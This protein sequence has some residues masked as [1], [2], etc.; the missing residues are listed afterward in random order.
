M[1]RIHSLNDALLAGQL[2]NLLESRGIA[3]ELRNLDLRTGM[4]EIPLAE[5][6]IELWIEDEAREGEAL[7]LIRGVDEGGEDAAAWT[8]PDCGESHEAQF[9]SC[10]K[11][12]APSPAA[13][14]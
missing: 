13:K 14:A 6:W 7:G 8:C 10:W 2:R 4:G 11:C 12:G 9:D 5:C 1:K 3:C